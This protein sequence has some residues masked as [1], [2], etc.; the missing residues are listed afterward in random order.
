MNGT[1]G[2]LIFLNLAYGERELTMSLGACKQSLLN[3]TQSLAIT[4]AIAAAVNLREE[5]ITL[6]VMKAMV[7]SSLHSVTRSLLARI[8]LTDKATSTLGGLTA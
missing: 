2:A 4:Y 1:S 3:P 6:L 5:L 8:S 7:T